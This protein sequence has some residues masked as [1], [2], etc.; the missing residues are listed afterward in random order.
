IAAVLTLLLASFPFYSDLAIPFAIALGVTL[1]AG[2]TLLPALL[3]L[4]LSLLAQKRTVFQRVFGKPKLLPWSIQ[5]AGRP[6]EWGR[7][8]PARRPGSPPPRRG[9]C[10]WAGSSR[11]GS[12]S[13]CAATRPRFGAAPPPRPRTAPRR[14]AHP[15]CPA[16]S[17]SRRPTRP[18]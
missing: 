9:P 5:G 8:A 15:S 13:R 1:L 14:R 7:V 11:R 12:P 2:L 3:S 18:A 4:R 10:G 6:G 17:R 16:T